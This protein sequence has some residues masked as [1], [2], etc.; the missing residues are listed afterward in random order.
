VNCPGSFKCTLPPHVQLCVEVATRNKGS[1]DYK[2]MHMDEVPRYLNAM[3]LPLH[4][5]ELK[6][7]HQKDAVMNALLGRY[8]GVALDITVILL[9]PID[10]YWEEMVRNGATFRG[11]IYRLNAKAHRHAEATAV[12]F[13]MSRKDGIF[14]VATRNQVQ[15]MGDMATTKGVY[16]EPYF[17]LGDQTLTPILT[18][19][20][21][22]LP[23]CYEDSTVIGGTAA[24]PEFAG[25][26]WYS[27]VTGPA[28][29]DVKLM[30]RD[31]RDGPV[32]P[33]ALMP[34]MALWNV[35]DTNKPLPHWDP[36]WPSP[37]EKGGPMDGELCDSM[38]AC[39]DNVFY[40]RFYQQHPP[41][42]APA[43]NFVKMFGAGRDLGSLSREA[44]LQNKDTYFYQ[45][46]KLAGHPCV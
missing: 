23:K 2:V 40:R 33:Y 37:Y 27:G 10:I 38:K 8:G 36:Q 30:L 32:L 35:L 14:S 29:N 41:N 12:W 6:P 4:W 46:L 31:P 26:P 7:Q 28:R 19:T 18:A 45:W 25:P 13:L 20:N 43:L 11:Y 34:G 9:R 17:A 21:Y 44:L 24:C 42:E 3:E 5:K 1:F 15:G 16:K 22:N 39:W